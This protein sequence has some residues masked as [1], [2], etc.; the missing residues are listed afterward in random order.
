M[1]C[2]SR[3]RELT[4]QSFVQPCFFASRLRRQSV[5]PDPA[6]RHVQGCLYG[7]EEFPHRPATVRCRMSSADGEPGT[8]QAISSRTMQPK[9]RWNFLS[10]EIQRWVGTDQEYPPTTLRKSSRGRTSDTGLANA[11]FARKKQLPWR[12]VDE[13]H[14][15]FLSNSPSW[16]ARQNR[17]WSCS[18]SE[19][20]RPFS[21]LPASACAPRFPTARRAFP[22]TDRRPL[23]RLAH[24]R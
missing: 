14:A 23:Q 9:R 7:V 6:F 2:C 24:R 5:Q 8:I 17:C 20:S 12:V 19:C 3:A 22:A 4:L 15:A 21:L 10:T 16:D 1:E 11:P 18:L 13:V